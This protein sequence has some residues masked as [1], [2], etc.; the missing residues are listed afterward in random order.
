MCA[1]ISRLIGRLTA[2]DSILRTVVWKL[3]SGCNQREV[4]KVCVAQGGCVGGLLRA[5]G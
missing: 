3:S 4:A 5:W 1:R 2:D